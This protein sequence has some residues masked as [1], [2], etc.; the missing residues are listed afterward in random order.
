MI[1][2]QEFTSSKKE[3]QIQIAS[4]DQCQMQYVYIFIDYFHTALLDGIVFMCMYVFRGGE[5]QGE[6]LRR[7]SEFKK[8]MTELWF[9]L[10]V[11]DYKMANEFG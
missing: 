7:S 6:V 1:I 9:K 4:R 10:Y 5:L 2:P 3:F 11:R 8:T